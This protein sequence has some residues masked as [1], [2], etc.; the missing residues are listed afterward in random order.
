MAVNLSSVSRAGAAAA[1]LQEEAA[2]LPL[3]QA[4]DFE[5]QLM[6]A[7]RDSLVGAGLRTDQFQIRLAE[8]PV[9][10]AG[11]SVAARQI[12]VSFDRPLP[13]AA[14]SAPPAQGQGAGLAAAQ[15]TA[16]DP[17]EVLRSALQSAGLDPSRLSMTETREV[18]G[19]PGGSYLNHQILVQ[20]G[21]GLRE[22]YDV[23]LML[24]NP[25]VTVTEIRRALATL[26]NA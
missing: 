15:Q 5:R 19:Y 17:V 8:S 20:F 14:A 7:I 26:Q 23:R 3:P 9:T 21:G 11:G 10:A 2:G 6:G 1:F 4:S 16:G 22:S 18:V 25:S 12:L 24:H 13:A